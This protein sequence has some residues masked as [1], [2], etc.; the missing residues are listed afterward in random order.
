MVG[1]CLEMASAIGWGL[2]V[3]SLAGKT[4]WLGGHRDASGQ[5]SGALFRQPR[6]LLSLPA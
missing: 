2:E 5:G 4:L 3:A 1:S 6:L